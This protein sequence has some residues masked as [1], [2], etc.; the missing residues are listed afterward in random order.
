MSEAPRPRAARSAAPGYLAEAGDLCAFVSAHKAGLP[1]EGSNGYV[2]PRPSEAA[3]MLRAVELALADALDEAAAL[4]EALNY[5]LVVFRDTGFGGSHLMLRERLPY[6]SGWGL[7]LVSRSP[8]REVTVEVPHPLW[9][10]YTPELGI[11]AYLG[12]GA[13]HFLMAGAHRY[14]NGPRSPVSDMAR[15]P[16]S[17]FQRLHESLT[18]ADGHVLQFHGFNRQNHPDYPDVVLSNGSGQ[19]HPELLRLGSAIQARG[20]TAGVFDGQRW[21]KLGATVNPQGRYTRQIGGRFYHLEL[22][23]V[24]RKDPDHRAS[25]LEAVEEG[26]FGE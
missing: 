5:D 25:V 10:T 9:D 3:L 8:S 19:P 14:A 6:R 23:H 17:L 20:P 12:L 26:L 21:S 7:F 18:G 24:L 11:E 13:R 1:G 16:G 4:L 22:R 15:N 2:D